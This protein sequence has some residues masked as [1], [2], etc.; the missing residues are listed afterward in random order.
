MALIAVAGFW[1][2]YL[3]PLF[4]GAFE[5]ASVIHLHAAVYAGW[6]ALFITQTSLVSGS[7]AVLHRRGV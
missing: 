7:R 2:S 1:P 5:H 6:L 4:T 3:G